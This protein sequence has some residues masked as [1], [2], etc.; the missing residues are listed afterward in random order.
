MRDE[1]REGYFEDIEVGEESET[2]GRT[3]TETDAVSWVYFTG[4]WYPLHVDEEFARA[5]TPF[6]TRLPPGLMVAAIAQGLG[7][8]G[9]RPIKGVAFL[10]ALL[11]YKKPVFIGDTVHVRTKV[12]EKRPTSRPDRGLV[13]LNVQV[14]NQRDEVVQDNEWLMLVAR[15]PAQQAGQDAA[16]S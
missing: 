9:G 15:R 10:E 1:R 13:R 4:E 2:T 3:I 16:K 6:G 14:V 11:R 8:Y 12:I 7:T 5:H